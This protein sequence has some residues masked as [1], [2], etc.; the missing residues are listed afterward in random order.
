MLLI[1]G[2]HER[3][4]ILI[5]LRKEFIRIMYRTFFALIH[6]I[7]F[8]LPINSFWIIVAHAIVSFSLNFFE[9][10]MYH[11]KKIQSLDITIYHYVITQFV[12]FSA[13][14]SFKSS[15]DIPS[16][17]VEVNNHNNIIENNDETNNIY[18]DID[19]NNDFIENN[20]DYNHSNKNNNSQNNNEYIE[21]KLIDNKIINSNNNNNS[22]INDNS[23]HS[24]IDIEIINNENIIV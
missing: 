8:L 4:G 21:D 13:K 17:D 15:R 23:E 2:M 16:M 9:L 24:N 6:L 19:N 18:D 1:R 3:L 20:I 5:Y 14:Y 22:D 10:F 12:S 7:L 11:R